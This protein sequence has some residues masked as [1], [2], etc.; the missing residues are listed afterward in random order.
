MTPTLPHLDDHEELIEKILVGD[1]DRN[2]TMVR[3]RIAG[4]PECQTRLGEL[5]SLVE[6]MELEREEE[7]DILAR[8]DYDRVAPG[9]ELVGPFFRQRVAE[10]PDVRTRRRPWGR[11][12]AAAAILT[13]LGLWVTGEFRT[14]QAVERP[15]F[16][17]ASTFGFTGAVG[18]VREYGPVAWN[19][20]ASSTQTRYEITVYD[21]RA[22]AGSE[23]VLGP[24]VVTAPEWNPTAAQKRALPDA[25]RVMVAPLDVTGQVMGSVDSFEASRS[26]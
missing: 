21:D 22:G 10:L 1:L 26:R 8:L 4:C 23:T 25:I 6:L 18:A 24:F 7:R 9:S 2:D 17:G 5:T 3:S 12:A 16:L 14:T 11:I 13:S 15:T 19:P 20:I